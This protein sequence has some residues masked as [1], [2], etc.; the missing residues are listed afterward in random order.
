MFKIAIADE[1]KNEVIT[2]LRARLT[3]YNSSARTPSG[4]NW[5]YPDFPRLDLGKN[6]YPRIS[7]MDVTETAEIID[8]GRNMKYFP[9]LQIDV[10]VWAGIDGKDSNLITISTVVYEWQK[11]LDLVARDVISALDTNKSDFDD[12]TNILHNLKMLAKIDMG[13]DP[14]RRQ[15]IRKR[16]E[17]SF[18]YYR[19]V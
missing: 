2:V 7:V 13:A 17:I 6:S 11:L 3:D 14:E 8:I 16:I 12:D 9:R 10:W 5:I 4:S 19:G 1:P 18:E 15:V